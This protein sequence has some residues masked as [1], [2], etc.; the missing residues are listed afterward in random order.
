MR[1]KSHYA[2]LTVL[3]FLGMSLSASGRGL[4]LSARPRQKD[5]VMVINSGYR[6]GHRFGKRQHPVSAAIDL[7]R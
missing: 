2:L 1:R 7:W 5:A 6:P 4:R 3:F